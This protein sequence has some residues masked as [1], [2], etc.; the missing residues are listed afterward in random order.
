M[1]N[2]IIIA[3]I[4]G[5]IFFAIRSSIIHFKGQGSCCGGSSGG[6]CALEKKLDGEIVFKKNIKIQGMMCENCAAHVQNALNEINGASAKVNLKKAVAK[7][8]AIRE[9]PEEEI[10]MAVAKA[11][12][13]NVT[14]IENR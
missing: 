6:S 11:G 8:D 1:I 13:Y 10:R 3:V 5:A 9:V 7:F 4:V 14:S 2:V 12:N